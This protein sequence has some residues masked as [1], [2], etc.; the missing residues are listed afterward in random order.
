[1]EAI[2]CE[3]GGTTLMVR[4]KEMT[5]T[6]P[7]SFL[8]KMHWERL[9]QIVQQIVGAS[10]A[11]VL[12]P[13]TIAP[14]P[15]TADKPAPR[16][17]QMSIDALSYLLFVLLI[18][19]NHPLRKLHQAID[20]AKIDELCAPVYEN[21]KRGAPAYPPQVLFRVLVLMF[22]SGT[23]FESA[24]LRQ[25]KTDVAWRWFVGLGLL[26]PVPDGGTL[27]Y[28][29]KRLGVELFEA[30]LVQLI[31]WCEEAGLI[32]HVESYYDMTGV[33]AS[34]TQVT[35]YQRAVIL[36][37]AISVYLDKEAGGVGVISQEQIAAIALEVLQ[38][39]HPSL[40]K[41]KPT[42]IVTSQDKLTEKMGSSEPNW[43]QRVCQKVQELG[44]QW[45][46]VP[47][48]TVEQVREVAQQ[49]VPSLPQAFGN[50]DAAVGHT[51]T[52]GT[53]CGYRSGFLV[54][55]KQRIITA[56]IFVALNVAEAPTLST[57][58]D[59]H[60]EIFARYPERL[61][62]DSAFDRDEVHQATAQREILSVA[63]ARSRPGPKGVFHADAFIWNEQ[64]Q[65]ICP[66]DEVMA[67]V[68]GPY[69]DGTDRYRSK[70]ECAPCPL[71]DQCLTA[72]QQQKEDPRRELKTNTA[73]HKRAQQNRERS[74]SDEGWGLRL[75]RFAAEGL[76]GHLNRYHNGDKAPYRDGQMDHIAQLMVAFTAN[77]EQL[78]AHG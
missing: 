48:T 23:P 7:R 40:K 63:T 64:G 46:G 60:Y 55:A 4:E 56:V 62:L 69:K 28:F 78:A 14:L 61:G 18:P 52:N 68:A 30:I 29:R 16:L 71:F 36:A 59:K 72:S 75:R 35:P 8:S 67:Q 74:R 3:I 38:K 12:A 49:L 5:I 41:V 21:E 47:Q 51:R 27:S 20:W 65:L 24:T 34:A 2:S 17:R 10:L 11:W 57:A 43:W 39:K 13:S 22:Y 26:C 9:V 45:R 54:D 50:P 58:L 19:S 15:S 33:E 77:L 42:Q 32:G 6:I 73:A 66:H 76:F 1:M 70:V 53:L 25:L 44:Q 37:K 31:E